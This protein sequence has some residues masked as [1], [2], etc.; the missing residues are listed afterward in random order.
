MTQPLPL[1]EF[2]NRTLLSHQL[3]A[4]KDAGITEVII[5]YYEKAVGTT[6]DESIK[7]LEKELGMRIVC[8]LE[9]KAGGTA[10]ALKLAEAIITDEGTNNSPFILVNSDVLCSYP[11]RDLLHQHVKHAREGTVLITRDENP[12][13]YGVV[14]TDAKTGRVLHFVEKPSTFLSD[15]VNTG[16]YVFSPSI[17]KRI[18]VGR[19]VSMNE[20]LPIMAVEDEL[21]SMLLTGYWV[22]L[23][24]AD[25]FR[26]AV[27]QHLEINQFMSPALL[28]SSMADYEIRGNVMVHP[29]AKIGHGCVL[30][31]SVVV[32]PDCLIEDG[33]RLE[34]STLLQDVHVQAHAIIKDSIIGW[35]SNIGRWCFITNSM[36]GEDVTVDEALLINQATVLPH[37]E[38]TS[39][40]RS[41]QIVI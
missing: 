22:K 41:K 11:L 8:S 4:L 24:N 21:Q 18:P 3:Q 1:L 30:G 10:G 36:F 12:S 6:W 23:T 16:V 14:V 2:C 15:H 27:R 33:V 7:R 31:P 40:V 39:N 26:D 29:T 37:K 17:F 34:G 5:S 13:E 28:A 25:S 35:S 9:E 19:A 38:L 32:G 20:L